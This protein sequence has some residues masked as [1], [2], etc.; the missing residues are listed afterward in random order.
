MPT[1]TGINNSCFTLTLNNGARVN[2]A[3]GAKLNIL[4]K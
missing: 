3:V 4:G 2:M 1:V